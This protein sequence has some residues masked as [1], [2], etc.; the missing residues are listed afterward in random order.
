MYEG[1]LMHTRNLIKLVLIFSLIFQV[2]CMPKIL[3]DRNEKQARDQVL[4]ARELEARQKYPQ[5]QT[6]YQNVIKNYPDTYYRKKAQFLQISLLISPDNPAPDFKKAL[7]LLKEYMTLKL[8][9]REMTRARNLEFLLNEI[10]EQ[11]QHSEK[12]KDQTTSARKKLKSCSE[13]VKKLENQLEQ[14]KAI[15]VQMQESKRK[16]R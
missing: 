4:A 13:R 11:A 5:A 10:A 1:C 15:D 16:A 8:S 9:S 12:H 3:I 14:I 2:G 6:T 7:T